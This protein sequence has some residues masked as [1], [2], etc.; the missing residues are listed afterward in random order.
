MR[1]Q[2]L[3]QATPARVQ[4]HRRPGH[5]VGGQEHHCGDDPIDVRASLERIRDGVER[6]RQIAADQRFDQGVL[7]VVAAGSDRRSRGQLIDERI[8][9]FEHLDRCQ[10]EFFRRAAIPAEYLRGQVTD[11]L[12]R[13][14][15]SEFF[16]QFRQI[17]Q[18]RQ[19]LG[20]TQKER[21]ECAFIKQRND[22]FVVSAQPPRGDQAFLDPFPG[23]VRRERADPVFQF[24]P[25]DRWG[26]GL[27]RR[28][29]PGGPKGL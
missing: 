18:E 29:I 3:A 12:L 11:E 25:G 28:T 26:Q 17:P 22:P 19:V 21:F 1:V 27:D 5:A 23:L 2:F 15:P 6:L 10:A 16:E 4:I 9:R 20:M 7:I 14:I 13:L 24:V 8:D